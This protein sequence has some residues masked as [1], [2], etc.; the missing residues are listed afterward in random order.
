LAARRRKVCP[1][2]W[3]YAG[4]VDA[5]APDFT[6]ASDVS[7]RTGTAM[8]I[9][10]D[11]FVASLNQDQP[12][13]ALPALLQALWYEAHGDWER[14]HKITQ[15]QDTDDAAWVHAYLHRREG[16]LGNARYWYR[17][18]GRDEPASSLEDEWRLIAAA[19]I[20][21]K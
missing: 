13:P 4:G 3:W 5:I 10:L 1:Y 2:L 12:D 20:D 17:R 11:Q 7:D 16:D 21:A 6:Y 9:Q 14:A 8:M 18:S 19:L 15:K